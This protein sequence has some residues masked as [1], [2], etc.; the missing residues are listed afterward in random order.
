MARLWCL[1]SVFF[2]SFAKMGGSSGGHKTEA[3][4]ITG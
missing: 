1:V 2:F 4:K 3:D